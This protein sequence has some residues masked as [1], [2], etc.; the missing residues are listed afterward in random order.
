MKKIIACLLALLTLVST[1]AFTASCSKDK[2]GD[3]GTYNYGEV[4]TADDG[5]R[6]DSNG[7]LMDDLP[8]DLNYGGKEF[9]ILACEEYREELAP[10]EINNSVLN[11]TS[12]ARNKT[13]EDRLG[14]Q[15]N[16]KFEYGI[17]TASGLYENFS[18]MVSTAAM[19]G[20]G[21]Y[22]AIAAFSLG[23]AQW[24]LN[25]Y[26]LNLTKV[27]YLDFEKPWYSYSVL[28]NA[29]YDSIYYTMTN[30]SGTMLNQ[31]LVTYYNR[32]ML[33]SH[34]IDDIETLVL[35]GKWTMET[36]FE[37]AKDFYQDT[38]GNDEQDPED[39]FGLVFRHDTAIDSFFYGAGLN[40]TRNNSETGLPE[41]TF[42]DSGE[43]ERV[44]DFIKLMLKELQSEGVYF[45]T[46]KEG[47]QLECHET[48]K[49]SRT[50]FY[51]GIMKYVTDIPDSKT[52]GVA[53]T[54]KLEEDKE[55]I[56]TPN[57]DFDTWC[58]LKD[59]QDPD[60]SGAVIEA[61]ASGCYRTV[62]PAYY[63]ENLSY[64]Y[65]ESEN[66]VKM[67]AMIKD[68]VKIDF[69][70]VNSYALSAVI[71]EHIRNCWR[72]ERNSFYQWWASNSKSF[73]KSLNKVISMYEKS[74]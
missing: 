51:V 64:R 6:Y 67:F 38:N 12:Y 32:T 28:E 15:L 56:T 52:W 5:K 36:M 41:V 20:M 57:N 22:D 40:V 31:S 33:E 46:T 72:N 11:D 21:E 53:P 7:Y 66:G 27:D 44:V 29:F 65:S 9:W 24:A 74:E 19:S 4:S 49:D 54:P 42:A 34:G 37:Y 3:G 61:Y 43:M 47:D 55:Y 14:V 35:S 48:L 50:A 26:T 73:K 23:P 59:A 68:N 45:G 39:T 30:C 16:F 70:R 18:E 10:Q 25:G 63:D 60:M 69:G 8:E 13:I 62:A 58:I 71:D 2:D 17:P 1:I